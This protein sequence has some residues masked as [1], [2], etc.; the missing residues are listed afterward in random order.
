MLVNCCLLLVSGF[1]FGCYCFV[2]CYALLF[3]CALILV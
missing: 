2:L 1:E 3:V